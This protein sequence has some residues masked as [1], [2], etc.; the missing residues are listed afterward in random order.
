VTYTVVKEIT[1]ATFDASG[2]PDRQPG[3]QVSADTD[4]GNIRW[5]YVITD[6]DPVQTA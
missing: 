1:Q 4:L 6:A 2:N 5:K 3:E